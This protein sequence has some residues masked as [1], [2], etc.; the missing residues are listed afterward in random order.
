MSD[1]APALGQIAVLVAALALAVPFL[2]RYLA[3]VYTS[4]KHLRLERATYRVLRVDPDADQHWRSY[5]M[6][7]LGFSLVGVLAL[8]A[9][10]RLQ[11]H[12][13]LSLG[14]G[15]LPADGAWNTAVSFVTNTNWQWYSGEA[16]LG[17][18]MQMSGLT[19][20]NFVSAG[21][22][23]AVAA[24]FARALARHGGEGRIGSFFTD[25]VR[26]V[27]RVLLPISLFA[28]LVLVLLGVVQNLAGNADVTTLDGST[29]VLTGGPVASQEAIKQLGTN[30]GGFYNV[31]AAHPFENPTPFT[32]L[33][34]IFLMLLVPFAMAWAF[35][36]I[37]KD[38]RQGIAVVSVMGVLLSA[39]IGLLTWAELAGPGTAPQLAGAAME[40]KETRFGE[41]ASALFG[42]A[43]T[44]TSTGAVNSMHDSFTAP[45]GGVAM[46]NMMLGE[47]APG[48]VGSGLYG[49]LM[50]AVVTVFLC[51]LMVGRTPEYLG[52]K[53]GQREIVL[54]SAY[55]LTTP[56]LV[57]A[58]IAVAITASDG[59]AG[60]Q[61]TGPHGLSEALYAV[62]SAANNNG[63]SFGGLTSG[64]PFW[65]TLLGLLMLFGRFLPM[66]FVL[67]LAG[68]FA[69]QRPLPPSAGTLPTH[70]PLF[71]ALLTGVALVVVGLTYVPVLALGPIVESLS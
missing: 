25:L 28:A 12:L 69:S 45:G 39:G 62:T 58:G 3:H 9:F 29:Q 11:Q 42:A 19:V 66:L 22:G 46:F 67:A 44:G 2:G 16:A 6:S 57:L 34:E 13:P 59:L 17:H 5:A 7:V 32:N 71:V 50:L 26:T 24:A 54:V 41:A 20:Q 47:I 10:G 14:F 33:F 21:V 51:G 38:R 64:T 23:M 1:L 65:N 30:G 36:L 4:P 53:I 18:L 56:I 37:V 52:K 35:G 43:T 60:L 15:P 61:E 68:R 31:N 63:S 55:V 49:M 70:R 27:L 40:G 8:Y 48:G